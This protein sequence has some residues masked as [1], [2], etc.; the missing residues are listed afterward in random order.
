MELN[1][2]TQGLQEK[3]GDRLLSIVLY[4]SAACTEHKDKRSDLNIIVVISSMGID[5]LKP[6]AS[7]IR[8]W[9]RAGNPSPLFFT[10]DRIKNASDIFPIEYHDI[11]K[12]NRVLYGTDLFASLIIDKRNLR[13]QCES[14]LRGKIL[15]IE[16][17]GSILTDKPKKLIELMLISFS[18]IGAVMRGIIRL[19]GDEPSASRRANIEHLTRYIDFLPEP[20]YTIL[21]AREGKIKI[22]KSDACKLF[23]DYLTSL[24]RI[25]NFVDKL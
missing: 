14:E 22:S 9:R 1:D 2:L 25:T 24:E 21:D 11:Q 16:S 12:C 10:P 4:G 6:L 7:T 8:K 17:Q 18:S 23:D 15:F 5:V 20:F 13:H 3:L 19:M